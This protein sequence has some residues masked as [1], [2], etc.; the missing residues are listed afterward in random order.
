MLDSQGE[1]LSC[2]SWLHSYPYYGSWKES[3]S[4]LLL[5]FLYAAGHDSSSS[6]GGG[7]VLAVLPG[8]L[9]PEALEAP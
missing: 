2:G 3:S 5:C 7:P 1:G 9:G 8:H 4:L 6:T